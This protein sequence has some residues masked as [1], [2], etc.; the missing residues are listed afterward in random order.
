MSGSVTIVIVARNAAPTIKRAL[1]SARAQGDFPIVLVDDFSSDDTTARALEQDR[2]RLKVV[3]PPSHKTLGFARQVGIASIDTPYGVWLDADDALLPARV[4]RMMRAL[5]NGDSDFVFD[6]VELMDGPTGEFRR[7]LPIPDFLKGRHPLARL[8]E[9]NYLPGV[10]V[11]GFRTESALRIGYDAK[12]HGAEDIDFVLRAVAAG[13]RIQLLE[14]AGY[15]QYGYPFTLS[16]RIEN[17][18]RMYRTA[19]KKHTYA[20]VRMLYLDA[21]H[22]RR[23]ATWG[24]ASMAL[25]REEYGRALE[26]VDQVAETADPTEVLESDGP[27]PMPEG[28]RIS[29]YR[30]TALLL[31]GRHLEARAPLGEAVQE[32]PE[33]HRFLAVRREPEAISR[34]PGCPVEPSKL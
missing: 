29:F 11:F 21:C 28:W 30:G 4:D 16:R 14:G 17:Q 3:G 20:E 12:M 6:E 10:G 23:I 25:F 34:L 15:R 32:W 2:G 27:W 13:A 22:D 9:R 8:F 33:G 7:I 24:L 19:L 5:H 26:F 31:L 1:A 18:R